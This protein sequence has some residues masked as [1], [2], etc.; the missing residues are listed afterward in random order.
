MHA[1]VF[2]RSGFY[3][4]RRLCLV[5]LYSYVYN[6]FI[7]ISN[8][9]ALMMSTLRKRKGRERIAHHGFVHHYIIGDQE[10]PVH[11]A[12]DVRETKGQ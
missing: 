8:A 10:V 11:E 6:R 7:E 4:A 12:N 5:Q 2:S 1:W 9:S 3:G